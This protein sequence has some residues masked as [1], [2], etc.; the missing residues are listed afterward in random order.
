MYAFIHWDTETHQIDRGR[1]APP[2]VS[3]QWLGV[4]HDGTVDGPFVLPR[5]DVVPWFRW[6][7][8]SGAVMSGLNCAYDLLVV[9]EE[10]IR[11]GV[12]A[13]EIWREVFEWLV[14]ALMR[15]TEVRERLLRIA[16]GELDQARLSLGDQVLKYT[17]QEVAGKAGA[18][19]WRLQYSELE[20]WPTLAMIDCLRDQP[21]AVADPAAPVDDATRNARLRLAVAAV[22]REV[23][24]QEQLDA[25]VAGT[26]IP[27]SPRCPSTWPRAAWDYAALDPV[28]ERA[29]YLGQQELAVETFGSPDIP[30]EIAR[31]IAKFMLHLMASR[32]LRVDHVRARLAASSLEATLNS[33]RKLLV[34]HGLMREVIVHKGKP[35]ERHDGFSKNTKVIQARVEEALTAAGSAVKRTAPTPDRVHPK[36]GKV[37]KGKPNGQVSTDKEVLQLPALQDDDSLRIWTAFNGAEKLLGTYIVPLCVDNGGHAPGWCGLEHPVHWRYDAVKDTGRTSAKKTG[38]QT[39]RVSSTTGDIEIVSERDGNNVQNYPTESAIQAKARDCLGV[40]GYGS[41]GDGMFD[42]VSTPTERAHESTLSEQE[43]RELR[44]RQW[45]RRHDVRPIVVAR[46]GYKLLNRDYSGVEMATLAQCQVIHFDREVTLA[47]VLNH[48]NED[49]SIGL[50]PHCYVGRLVHPL[51]W[52]DVELPDGIRGEELLSYDELV[53]EEKGY[54]KAIKA[55][56]EPTPR[57]RRAFAT[58][59]LCK[60]VNFGFLGGMGAATFALYVW[61]RERIRITVEEAQE[62]KEA[63]YEAFPEMKDWFRYIGQQVDVGSPVV[64]IGSGRVRGGCTYT[65]NA[66]TRFQGLAAD[67]ALNA[68]FLL[69]RTC[70]TD[71]ASPLYGSF[72]LVFEHDA[73][74]IE[75]KFADPG[76]RVMQYDPQLVRAESLRTAGWWAARPVDAKL[77]QPTSNAH[78]LSDDDRLALAALERVLAAD[79]EL[80]RIMVEG[81]RQLVPDVTIKTEGT[82][83]SDRWEK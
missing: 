13:L 63:W 52:H 23:L 5:A 70:L 38:Y 80:E 31:P 64:Q 19:S 56:R 30:D 16:R 17:G 59:K 43:F 44:I 42:D 61:Q 50:D 36:T 11:R 37:I 48:K 77:N 1:P 35:N 46:P 20:R 51:L 55:G 60:V 67:G 2:P 8:R 28:Y 3:L 73:F 14:A 58:R 26:I 66:N 49:G 7:I 74:L 32:G 6:A 18:D 81:M 15:C 62:L 79:D 68:L 33:M 71:D 25:L 76:D 75:V 54:K 57:Q 69:W 10:A 78:L 12:P 65:Q 72:P 9:I 39:R 34:G 45:C 53:A 27:G 22:V 24:T 4:R 47:A 82:W 29:V 21:L 83:P 40:L 41:P